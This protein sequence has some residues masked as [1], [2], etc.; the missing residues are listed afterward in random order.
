[1][2]RL[3]HED[4]P[5]SLAGANV[6]E[7]RGIGRQFGDVSV[8][9][10]VDLDVASGDYVAIVGPS[11]SGKSTLLN[12][13]GCLDRPTSGTYRLD[14]VETTELDERGRTSARASLLGFVFQSFHLLSHL[15]IEEN[16]AMAE[17]YRHGHPGTDRTSRNDRAVACLEMVGMGHR[18]GYRPRLLSG[19]ERQRVAIAR[20]L[21]CRPAVLLCDEP[22][23]N[24]DQQNT[25][26]VLELFDELRQ[27]TPITILV[28][29]HDRDVASRAQ[30]VIEIRDGSVSEQLER[31]R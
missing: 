27:T 24:L 26:T 11:G 12:I 25:A 16:V 17:S 22:T 5:V 3:D 8:L 28:I 9:H 30:R 10:G 19:G 15:S 29:T 31:S 23:G 7:M 4:G 20:A 6:I 21:M 2:T 18:L 13:L 1:M 14:G